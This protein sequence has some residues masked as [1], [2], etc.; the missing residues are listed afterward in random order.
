[1]VIVKDRKTKKMESFLMT[2]VGDKNYLERKSFSLRQNSY[3][4]HD[5]DFSG[6]ILFHNLSGKFVNGWKY[7]EGKVTHTIKLN[8]CS[9]FP[10]Q[11][12]NGILSC[13]TIYYYSIDFWVTSYYTVG[14]GV[15]T[16]TGFG[17]FNMQVSLYTTTQCDYIED[18]NLT[19]GGLYL[20]PVECYPR[21][22]AIQNQNSLD[23]T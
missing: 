7:S 11:L 6:Q 10:V 17:N 18:E 9:D 19:G 16:F 20:P 1:M 14:G 21:V 22:S 2:I 4:H 23:S 3:L 8:E 5:K 15:E 12:K 13:T